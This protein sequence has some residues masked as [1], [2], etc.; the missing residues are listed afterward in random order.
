[1]LTGHPPF[2]EGSLAQRIL[3]H[4]TESPPSIYLDRKDAP[5]ELVDVCMRMMSKQ[6]AARFQTAAEISKTLAMW[7]ASRGGASK[8]LPAVP[9]RGSPTAPPRR[10]SSPPPR[11]SGNIPAP[12][13]TVANRNRETFK[14]PASSVNIG[15]GG[16]NPDILADDSH[17]GRSPGTDSVKAGGSGTAKPGSAK[18]LAVARPI[19]DAAQSSIKLGGT[20]NTSVP[21]NK[22][23]FIPVS[24]VDLADL[25][26]APPA[27]IKPSKKQQLPTWAI[28]VAGA[29]IVVIFL[30]LVLVFMKGN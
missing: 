30:L 20:S 12:D 24:S 25:P 28:Y 17:F 6:P 3:K 15:A 9:K 23:R 27:Q 5:K 11:R 2:R 21:V 13:D 4:Q 14:G 1:L 18:K 16:V 26:P 22:P 19:S 29:G 10:I 8:G 7:I